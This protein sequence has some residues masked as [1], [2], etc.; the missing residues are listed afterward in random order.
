MIVKTETN[1]HA[2]NLTDF[3]A[4]EICPL[5]ERLNSYLLYV[6]LH[7]SLSYANWESA[8]MCAI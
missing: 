7:N 8:T 4:L 1:K 5:H 6:L 3:I 2:V